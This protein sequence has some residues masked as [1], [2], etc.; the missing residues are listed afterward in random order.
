MA[1][2]MTHGVH[3]SHFVESPEHAESGVRPPPCTRA[4]SVA[5]TPPLAL[6]PCTGAESHL[7]SYE[8]GAVAAVS[9]D[10]N[11]RRAGSDVFM[12]LQTREESAT[13]SDPSSFRLQPRACGEPRSKKEAAA[14]ARDLT[15]ITNLQHKVLTGGSVGKENMAMSGEGKRK[16]ASAATST[17]S[18]DDNSVTT[19]SPFRKASRTAVGPAVKEEAI[20]A[21]T[22]WSALTLIKNDV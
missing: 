20:A 1:D 15:P 22:G 5:N 3:I 18:A 19:K 4:S 12:K 8:H 16:R 17:Y 14:V 10:S 9:K 13:L 11:T 7:S 21:V 6:R 2:S